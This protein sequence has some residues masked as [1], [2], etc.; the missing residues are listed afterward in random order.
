M[1][2]RGEPDPEL[3]PIVLGLRQAGGAPDQLREDERARR[4]AGAA[5]ALGL[6]PNPQDG[7]TQT[8][9]LEHRIVA[10]ARE[11]RPP[12]LRRRLRP[13]TARRIAFAAILLGALATA[14]VF[15]WLAFEPRD[16]ISGQ[17]VALSE[18]GQTGVLLPHYE[19]RPFA[20][21]F[22]GLPEPEDGEVWQ[23]WL[24]RES[25]AVT[26]GPVF[27]PDEEGR[28]AVAINPNAIESEDAPIG[29]AVSLDI[30]SERPRETADRE[31]I[32]Y[33]FALD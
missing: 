23:L 6:V 26:P 5:A 3:G 14:A 9:G 10:R 29:F 17:A 12:A 32:R 16:P 31:A 8:A 15:G 4:L 7:S 22:W 28:A 25:G 11:A 30:P 21:V 19:Q 24:V 13:S 27:S 33:Q 1:S 18:D 20:L 2:P